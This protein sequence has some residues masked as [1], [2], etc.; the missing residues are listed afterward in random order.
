MTRTDP[1]DKTWG[2]TLPGGLSATSVID[3]LWR[4]QFLK[5]AV[6]VAVVSV[7]NVSSPKS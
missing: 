4:I 6:I 3:S 5:A 2:F 7:I 1:N